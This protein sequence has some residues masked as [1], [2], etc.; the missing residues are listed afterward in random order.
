MKSRSYSK[1]E[2]SHDRHTKALHLKDQVKQDGLKNIILIGMPGVGKS[3]IAQ[4]LA[5]YMGCG[6][7]D[8]DQ[9]IEK[10]EKRSISQIFSQDGEEGFRKI[11]GRFIQNFL[12]IQNH[13]L[14]LGGGAVRENH[15]ANI[16]SLG[17]V[18]WIHVDPQI[19]VQRFVR[20]VDELKK[21]PLLSDLCQ[22]ADLNKRAALMLTRLQELLAKRESD[23]KKADIIF[24]DK[25]SLPW[26]CAQHLKSIILQKNFIVPFP[27]IESENPILAS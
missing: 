24:A 18:I 10:I 5:W 22:E 13:V 16:Q 19:L 6:H 15:W 25:Y 11:E 14:S 21:R 8:L 26:D 12:E 2:Q 20:N 27:G 17:L 4:H 3:V 9:Q 23:Y 1:D 7:V